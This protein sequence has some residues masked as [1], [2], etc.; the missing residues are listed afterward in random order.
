[1]EFNSIRSWNVRPLILLAALGLQAGNALAQTFPSKPLRIVVAYAP[2]GTVDVLARLIAP[3]FGEFLGQPVIV[4][5]RPGAGGIIGISSV[6]KSES[7]GHTLLLNPNGLTHV[8]AI[9]RKLPF[10]PA[11]DF[12]PVTQLIGTF[13]ILV[14]NPRALPA[15]SIQELIALAKSKPGALNYGSAGATDSLHITMELLK[16]SAGMDIQPVVY[17]GAGPLNTAL[18]AGE[19]QLAIMPFSLSVSSIKSGRLRA[20]GVTSL[21]RSPVLPDVPT[22]AEQ[23]VTGFES[24][25]WLGLF[26]PAKTPRA[27]V[28]RLNRE[29]VRALN[30]PEVHER[31][32]ASGAEPVGSTTE[33]FEARFKADLVK[34]VKVIKE[35]RIP[36]QD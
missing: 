3:K 4:E 18:L 9:Y 27:I 31:I 14:S 29:S 17:K 32:V 10:D 2:G 7:D 28:E 1:M 36:M 23:G 6:A 5:N 22:I 8:P 12:A 13:L 24:V 34:W 35:A 19:V 21:K 20:L 11:T 30:T 26:V 15:A 16:S 25:G 33:E